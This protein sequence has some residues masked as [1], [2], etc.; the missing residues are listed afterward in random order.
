MSL[1]FTWD[2][3]KASSNLTKHGVSF[4]EAVTA[5]EDPLSLTIPDPGHSET[6]SRYVLLGATHQ[7]RLVAVV[8]TEF[9]DIIR[10]VSA[11]MA[12]RRE[13]RDYEEG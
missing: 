4:E 6:E 5:F 1:T 8:H 12:T 9:G 7:N 2:L 3:R 10:V 13:R 11:R